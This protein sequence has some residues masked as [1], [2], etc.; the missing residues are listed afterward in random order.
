MLGKVALRQRRDSCATLQRSTRV[1]DRWRPMLPNLRARSWSIEPGLHQ[2]RGFTVNS[3]CAAW[4]RFHCR[5]CTG[6]EISAGSIRPVGRTSPRPPRACSSWTSQI[7]SGRSSKLHLRPVRFRPRARLNSAFSFSLS[8]L[9]DS[10]SWPPSAICGVR[11]TVIEYPRNIP[12]PGSIHRA[13]VSRLTRSR[14]RSY[15]AHKPLQRLHHPLP[16][17]LR[18][19]VHVGVVG[20]PTERV[21]APLQLLVHLVQQDVRQQRR[22]R[23]LR[24]PAASLPSSVTPSR[25]P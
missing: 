3:A 23:N 1:R 8:R 19:H 11:S 4:K 14:S 25:R 16:G 2:L 18:P 13:R 10:V 7:N 21:T 17:S 20:V 9:S 24:R 5:H 15:T 22:Q 12:L 6:T